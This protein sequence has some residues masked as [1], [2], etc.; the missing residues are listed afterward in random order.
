MTKRK[1]RRCAFCLE[2]VYYSSN[3]Y[4]IHPY[5]NVTRHC[6][7]EGISAADTALNLVLTIPGY[8]VWTSAY[9][10]AFYTSPGPLWKDCI[11]HPYHY[12]ILP[13]RL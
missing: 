5:A 12:C 1:N 10:P 7:L 6:H 2:E 9:K 13:C 8:F 4:W 3:K 11:S